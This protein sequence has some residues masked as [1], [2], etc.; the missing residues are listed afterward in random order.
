MHA[1]KDNI[2]LGAGA[3][4]FNKNGTTFVAI[5][6]ILMERDIFVVYQCNI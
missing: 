6:Q 5:S 2:D 4:W 3:W 1:S